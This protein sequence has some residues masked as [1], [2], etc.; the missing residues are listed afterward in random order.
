MADERHGDISEREMLEAFRKA[1]ESR[2]AREAALTAVRL[3]HVYLD[4]DSYSDAL[5]YFTQAVSEALGDKL[6]DS[7]V[8]CTYVSIARCHLGLGSCREARA[9]CARLD[10][11]ELADDESD[12]WAEAN[13]V[14]A[15]IEIECGRYAE[16]LRAAEKAYEVLRTRPDGTLLAEAGK[17][18][19]V[20]NA[21][22][23]NIK[24]ARDY[25]TDY[26]VCQKRLGSDAGLAGA[27]NNLGILAKRA[28]DFNGA[29]DYFESALKIDRRL[30]HASAI[31]DK[32]TNLGIVLY[33]LSR[34]AEAE[35]H[36]NEARDIYMRIGAMRGVVA[37][38]TTLANVCRV[39]REWGRAEELL[40]SALRT[41]RANGYLRSEA[42]ALEFLGDLEIARGNEDEALGHY[43]RA[44]GCAYRLAS[45]SDVVGEVL[46]RRA[47]AYLSVGRIEEA[48]RDCTDGL[49]LVR[50]LGDR[51]EEGALLRCLASASYAKGER[52]A[53]EVLTGRAEELLRRTGETFELAK[54]ELTDGIGLRES[55][56][57][58]DFPLDR[59]EARLSAAEAAF[60]RIGL[61]DWVARC[62]LER[63][64]ALELAGQSDRARSWLERAH[65]KF[66][67]SHDRRGLAEVDALLRQL[68]VELA[69]A[70]VHDRGRYPTIVDAY[71]FLETSEPNAEDVNRF[72]NEIADMFSVDRL[73]LFSLVEEGGPVV[74]TSVDRSGRGLGEVVR[75]VKTTVARRGYARPLVVIDGRGEDARVPA[76]VAALAL[77]PSEIGS[78]RER[79]YLLY[80]DRSRETQAVAFRRSDIEFMSAAARMLAVAHSRLSDSVA[81]SA[82]GLEHA[83][84]SD[85]PNIITRDPEML[86]ILASVERLQDSRVPVLIRGESGVGKELVA[87][88]IHES[89]GPRRG[90]FVAL[91]AGAIAPHLQ[92]S[93]LFGHVKGAFT[94][95]DRDRQGLVAAAAGGTLFLDE[96][97]EM[98]K[99]LQVKLLRF[100]QDG[101]Y[102]RVG[103]SVSRTS[104]ARVISASNKDLEKEV[105]G[106]RFRRD[107]FY[108]ICA[109]V[110]DVPP[111]RDR[112]DDVPLL[113]EHFLRVYAER[114]GKKIAGFSRDVRE[115]FL[116]HDWRGNNIRE[117]ENEVRRG[118]ALCAD[119]ESIGIDKVRPELRQRYEPGLG[120]T[121]EPS[122]RSLKAEV[123]ALEKSRILEALERTRWNKQRAADLLGLSRPGL[124]AKMKKYGIG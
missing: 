87:R 88:A 44:L 58:D 120:D 9:Y 34:W 97:G 35:E 36:L 104:D 53:A 2:S 3:G 80:A 57:G 116:K 8:G 10:D 93:E 6:S 38:Q 61:G 1:M 52:A 76:G 82:R 20:A 78:R 100:L 94:D 90:P 62:Q 15:R 42:L 29:L 22:L 121:D 56:V 55:S 7:E 4:S 43:S 45:S 123:E 59:I 66:E 64:K 27:Y 48:E 69:D 31:A 92:E 109:V 49:K 95:A 60:T 25:F 114:E 13:V 37:T 14:L 105:H 118:V 68:D 33:R 12:V 70:G 86:R 41:G 83:S 26:L 103:E 65:L 98:G 117:L 19:G 46:R 99:G 102:R 119:G 122:R 18:L 112:S 16:A 79:V 106:G 72:A 17:A 91:N 84:G 124:H 71:R 73:V 24:A 30:G 81:W 77:I 47:E 89:G 28:G 63:G 85:F 32:L 113:M 11:L 54:T 115:L 5:G 108:R 107:L 96:I 40:Q 110:I 39:R 101:E 51:F 74:A 67:V 111:L 50:D 21:E 75:F 23:G